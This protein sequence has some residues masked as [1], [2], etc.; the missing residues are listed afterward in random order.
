M[1][2]STFVNKIEVDEEYVPPE[3]DPMCA[4]PENFPECINGVWSPT[5]GESKLCSGSCE[6][7]YLICLPIM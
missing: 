2:I 1:L 4:N 5:S 6:T 3:P 7:E